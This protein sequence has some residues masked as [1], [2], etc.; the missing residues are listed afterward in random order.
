MS[1]IIHFKYIRK[2]IYFDPVLKIREE[3]QEYFYLCNQA[4]KP[5]KNKL[6]RNKKKVT[7][8]NCLKIIKGWDK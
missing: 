7:C 5:N 3:T 4:V 1:D 6:T 2:E 8:K